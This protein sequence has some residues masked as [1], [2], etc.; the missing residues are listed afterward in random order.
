[1]KTATLLTLAAALLATAPALAKDG[2][3]GLSQA[4]QQFLQ[5]S[6][7]GDLAE[8]DLGTL[9][10][11]KGSTPA[12]REFARWMMSTHGFAGRELT[13]ISQ[14]MHGE[15]LPS[16]PEP[17]A[18]VKELMGKL[19]NLSGAEFDKA[20]LQ[21]IVQD[22]EK[23]ARMTDAEAKDGQDYLIKS[24][25][26]NFA[27]AIKEHLAQAKL[28]MADIKNEG[29]NSGAESDAN[30]KAA[31]GGVSGPAKG[32]DAQAKTVQKQHQ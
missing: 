16:K 23:A 21:A 13:T 25:A 20:Y 32:N 29:G 1:M 10:A 26:A 6:A 27:P 15:T 9:A 24:F 28:L 14:K 7:T 31:V 30:M 4:D 8:S 12:V 17:K 22:H 18:E 3:H 19:Q 11:S 5:E 2:A